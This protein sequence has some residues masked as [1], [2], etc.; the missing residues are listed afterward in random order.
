[1]TVIKDQLVS[2]FREGE[3][4]ENNLMIG[5]EFEHII[6]DKQTLETVLYEGEKGVKSI[7]ES[8]QTRGWAGIYEGTN[9]VGVHNGSD[10][11][12][13]EP[14]A[15]F[16]IS[17][18]KSDSLKT[19]ETG[20]L[21]FIDAVEDILKQNN[22]RL[23]HRGYQPKTVISDIPFIP[24]KRYE[25]MSDYL[26]A[27]GKYALN[28]MK[29]TS[30]LQVIIDYRNEEDFGKKIRV[31]NYLSPLFR[32]LFDNIN[33]FEGVVAKKNM[34]RARIWDNMDNQR[35]GI[36]KDTLDKGCYTYKDYADFL[37]SVP[38]ILAIID[39]EY[40]Y[41]KNRKIEELYPQGAGRE[42][43]EHLI[44]MVF[45]DIRLKQYLEIRMID[46]LPY[47]LNMGAIALIKGLFYCDKT[48]DR[49]YKESLS[50]DYSDLEREKKL[51]L[52]DI[53]EYFGENVFKTGLKLLED[54]GEGLL[55]EERKYLDPLRELWNKNRLP[56]DTEDL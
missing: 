49:L 41:T 17:M 50:V 54:S 16:E 29:G 56:K 28:M 8:L 32:Y 4:P 14:G 2:Y 37:L 51:L 11:V 9:L 40:V 7:I 35:C 43:I 47:P 25:Y 15:Q 13:L 30:S 22:Y 52:D 1:M 55:E 33:I 12:T 36:I 34:V 48:V 42:E 21:R 38:P 20:Y 53:P 46:A 27:Q 10:Y 19:I 31:A 3:K 44:T 45:P 18:D 39:G 23:C 6:V 24:K 5:A 26:Q